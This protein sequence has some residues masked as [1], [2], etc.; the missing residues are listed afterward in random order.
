MKST[1]Q[2]ILNKMVAIECMERGKLC[3]M[4]NGRYYN[5]QSWEQGRNV[6]RYVRADE[7]ENLKK[8]IEGY[9]EFMNLAKNYADLVVQETRKA[10]QL[11][12]NMPKKGKKR[13][14]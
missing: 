7:V 2:L 1:L 5:L 8:A 6:V 11:A 4:R 3:S 14:I 13:G 12:Q 9:T 10:A